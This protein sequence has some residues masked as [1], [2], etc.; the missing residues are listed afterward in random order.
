[1]GLISRVSSRTY[2]G[3]KNL[4][5]YKMTDPGKDDYR[6]GEGPSRG[7]ATTRDEFK[8]NRESIKDRH[9]YMAGQS[10]GHEIIGLTNEAR[11]ERPWLNA[12]MPVGYVPGLG[13]GATGFTTRSDIGPA[14]EVSRSTDIAEFKFH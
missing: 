9:K 6:P 8:I 10:V 3:T 14:R 11:N 1:M 5:K 7:I 13:R 4:T 2:R 12:K